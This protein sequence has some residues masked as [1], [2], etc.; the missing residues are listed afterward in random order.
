M[1][2]VKRP[3]L[4][5]YP[6]RP[7]ASASLE[8]WQRYDLKCNETEKAN[9]KIMDE[10]K[11]KVDAVKSNVQKKESIQKKTQGLHGIALGRTHKRDR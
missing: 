6:K 11:K 10:Y 9:S 2:K 1:A 3:R 4:K 8:A 5:R 7:K